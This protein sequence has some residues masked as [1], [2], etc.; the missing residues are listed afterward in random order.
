VV[1]IQQSGTGILPVE[2]HGQDAH[3]TSG[4]RGEAWQYLWDARDKMTRVR[5]QPNGGAMADVASY[6]YD[7]LGRR[8][9][10]SGG[11]DLRWVSPYF[12]DCGF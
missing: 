11:E 7:A 1:W 6:T 9:Q 5:K 2:D 10:Q 3:A 8:F 12:L 4:A